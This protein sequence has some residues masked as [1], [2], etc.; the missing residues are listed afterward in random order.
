MAILI[1]QH[2]ESGRP[3]RLGDVLRDH[4]HRLDVRELHA[5]DDPPSDLDGV[6]GVVSLGGPMNVDEPDDHPWMAREMELLAEAHQR[7]LPVVG[8]CLG[9]QLLAKALGGDV[10]PMDQ[11]EVGLDPVT[12]TGP[13]TT[14]PLYGGLPWRHRV[15]HLHTREVVE[16]PE[17]GV[18][19]A[20]SSR[21][22]HQAFKI[23]LTTYGYQYHFE[24]TR[25]DI[26]Q[27]LARN[28]A[29]LERAG[30]TADALREQ[31]EQH[32]ELYRHL[33]DRLCRNIAGLL[34]PVDK[35]F[36]GRHAPAEPNPTANWQ[37]ARS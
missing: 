37:P 17:G 4:S 8:V 19:L 12:L 35:R 15:C 27:A 26:D 11:P 16:L 14:D 25:G 10:T 7:E 24:W 2:S 21:C 9:A 30:V 22:R 23:G 31:V 6:D 13:G 20:G 1:F 36:G 32:Y 5:G 18:G 28:S 34:M 33:G 3:A 29:T